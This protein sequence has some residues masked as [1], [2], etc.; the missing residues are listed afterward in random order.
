MSRSLTRLFRTFIDYWQPT[1][2]FVASLIILFSVY[3]YKLGSLTK[4]VDGQELTLR[5]AIAS[6]NIQLLDILRGSENLAFNSYHYLLQ[7]TPF[8]GAGSLRF[9]SVLF[10]IASVVAVYYL[11]RHWYT[12]RLAF[13]AATIYALSAWLLH[14]GRYADPNVGYLLVPVLLASW[15]WVQ[16]RLGSRPA[17]L[18]F[19]LIL[20]TMLYIPGMA[21]L[22][23]PLVVWQRREIMLRIRQMHIVALSG[24]AVLAAVALLPLLMT[25]FWPAENR[26][27]TSVVLSF[28][29]FESG[30]PSL[31]QFFTNL[32]SIPA[33][34]FVSYDYIAQLG[35]RGPALVDFFTGIMFAVGL[36]ISV[37]DWR[38]DRSKTL[39]YLLM[40]GWLFVAATGLQHI[41]LLLP[42][43]YLV[44]AVGMAFLLIEWFG[45]FPRNPLARALA[46]GL[47]AAATLMVCA[48]G[49]RNY[50]VAWPQTERTKDAYSHRLQ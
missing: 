38:L 1:A 40:A 22:L 29:G 9:V 7:F 12:N 23:L 35:I 2:T 3:I 4:G 14:T 30:L 16:R 34:I 46:V 5:D 13:M 42:V 11:V 47:A 10:A 27:F 45:V 25:V 33:H 28:I 36:I 49:L 6:G 18:L 24:T 8:R 39:L 31:E 44:S 21:V 20:V 32:L 48:Y 43:V 41:S 19:Y 50:F 26:S 15:L 37:R 17:L